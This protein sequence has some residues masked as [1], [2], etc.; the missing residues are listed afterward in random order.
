MDDTNKGTRMAIQF[1]HQT[2][3]PPGPALNLL[4]KYLEEHRLGFALISV[5][6]LFM[7]ANTRFLARTDKPDPVIG[8]LPSSLLKKAWSGHL[9][10]QDRNTLSE[11]LDPK[12]S[13]Y[14]TWEGTLLETAG[15]GQQVVALFRASLS[16]SGKEQLFLF[17][18]FP[19]QDPSSPLLSHFLSLKKEILSIVLDMRDY[20]TLLPYFLDRETPPGETTILLAEESRWIEGT[21]FLRITPREESSEEVPQ[22]ISLRSR[23]T[24]DL[25]P[26]PGRR[27]LFS[28]EPS[29]AGKVFLN[30]PLFRETSFYGWMIFPFSGEG[31]HRGDLYR[32]KALAASDLSGLLHEIRSDLFMAPALEKESPGGLYSR[33][34]ILKALQDLMSQEK[35]RSSFGLIGITLADPAG[36]SPLSTHLQTF[37]R[38]SDLLGQVSPMEFI[39]IVTDADRA[40]TQ[41]TLRRLLSFLKPLAQ[42]NYRLNARIGLCHY[43]EDGTTPLRITRKV[44]LHDTVHIGLAYRETLFPDHMNP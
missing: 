6:G 8:T 23:R 21:S 17:H 34:G 13:T 37:L 4:D 26:P 12:D 28:K 11:W 44:F 30:I 39:L 1:R 16:L 36:I 9:S 19:R 14:G 35:K 22:C 3:R 18:S 29:S 25:F 38:G 7:A 41:K 15:E 33:R 10:G 24:G 2:L 31:I 42:E 20:S 40:R 27:A 32:K 43:P 5:N